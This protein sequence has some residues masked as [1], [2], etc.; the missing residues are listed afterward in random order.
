MIPNLK[1]SQ[2]VNANPVDGDEAK[3]GWERVLLNDEQLPNT[4]KVFSEFFIKGMTTVEKH[5]Q[6]KNQ[7]RIAPYNIVSPDFLQASIHL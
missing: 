6:E 4:K 7:T 3:P 5:V 1:P 2:L